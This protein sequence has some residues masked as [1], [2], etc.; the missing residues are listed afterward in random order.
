LKLPPGRF[1]KLKMRVPDIPAGVTMVFLPAPATSSVPNN[2]I[3]AEIDRVDPARGKLVAERLGELIARNDEV[4]RWL[5]A[6]P[7]HTTLFAVDPVAAL[8]E[9]LPDLRAD[10]FDGW[11]GA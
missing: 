9:A 3:L 1:V 4:F 10:F 8:R 6:S 2:G 5:E 11:K 7:R